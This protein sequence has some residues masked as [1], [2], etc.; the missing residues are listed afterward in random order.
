[1]V[2]PHFSNQMRFVGAADL[3]NR[4]KACNFFRYAISARNRSFSSSRACAESVATIGGG[5]GRLAA[6]FWLHV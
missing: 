5:A 1:M 3:F 4:I 6:S 2:V